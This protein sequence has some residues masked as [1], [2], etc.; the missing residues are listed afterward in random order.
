LVDRYR[1]IRFYL[2]QDV[3]LIFLCFPLFICWFSC[4]LAETNRSPYDFSEGERELVSG[5]NVEYGGGGFALLFISEYSMIIFLCFF[6]VI[7]FIGGDF[8]SFFFVLK[9]LIFCFLYIWLRSR[10]PRY[11]YDKLIN[12]AWKCYLPF[13]LNF[14]FYFIFLK[15]IV[16]YHFFWFKLLN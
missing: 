1:L 6:T 7:L 5:F 11:R 4:C 3:W 9:I 2:V 10:L 15:F 12:I 14:I 8:Y 16:I 13:S